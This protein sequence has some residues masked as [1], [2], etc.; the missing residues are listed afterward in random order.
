MS[1]ETKPL[2]KRS[3]LI[4][5]FNKGHAVAPRRPSSSFKK[6]FHATFLNLYL[7]GI[8]VYLLVTKR[9]SVVRDIIREVAGFA[10]YERRIQELLKSGLDK[11]ALKVAKKKVNISM[12]LVWLV[13]LSKSAVI[14]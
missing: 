13:S 3:G 6:G 2:V 10:P 11:R 12:I 4:K 8:F 14:Y 5:G 9:V 1:T 7:L